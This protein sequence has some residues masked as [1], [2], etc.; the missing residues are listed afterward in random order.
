MSETTRDIELNRIRHSRLNPRLGIDPEELK[1]LTDSIREV[2]ILQPIILR[3]TEKEEYE[4]VVGERRF[5][6]AKELGL[7][8]IRA[9][10]RE[11]SDE[12]VVELNLIENV[13][14][15]ELSA[16]EK[17]RSCKELMEKYPKTYP[18]IEGV[19]FKIGV[20]PS[21]V[22]SWLQLIEAPLE[23]QK[24]VA[25]APKLGTPRETGKIDWDTA[26]SITRRIRDKE[27]QVEVAREIASK[28]IYGREAREVITRAAKDPQK[29]VEELIKEV[30]ETPFELPFRL[31][32]MEPILKNLKTQT[33]RRGIPDP[34][35]KV[36]ARIHGAVW[37]PHFADL[38]ITSIKRKRLG[39]FT[40]DDAK[41]EGGYTLA[42][43]K[44]VW[45]SIH[46]GWNEGES[47]YV[48]QFRREEERKE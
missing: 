1:Q 46:G 26:V 44:D 38:V 8:T 41:R 24:M 28:P 48:I 25:P 11:Y 7:K 36:G 30:A 12:E 21:T 35:V 14:R 39:D 13:Q 27:R 29:P 19:A 4:V 6:A 3:P 31:S 32:H 22:R 20:S 42:Q 2:G 15:A 18:N 47:V 17:G 45:R 40:E 16:V 33:S 10:V 23:I 43:F 34:K 37:E 9:V 5:A